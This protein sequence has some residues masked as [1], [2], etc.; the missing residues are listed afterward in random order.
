MN[1]F[2]LV[3]LLFCLIASNNLFS[4]NKDEEDEKTDGTGS[5]VNINRDLVLHYTFDEGTSSTSV[6]TVTDHSSKHVNGVV[7]GTAEFVS[8]TP[9]GNGY[10]L[11]LRKNDYVNIPTYVINDST[12]V[13]VVMWV[14]DFG[15]GSLFRS[16][17]GNNLYT[18]HVS[19]NSSDQLVYLCADDYSSNY[20]YFSTNMAHYQTG[21]WH[22]IAVTASRSN[23]K[24]CLYID[25]VLFDTKSVGQAKCKGETMQ[26]GYNADPMLVDNVRVYARC[27]NANEVKSIYD[28]E[29]KK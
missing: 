21:T 2:F 5:S 17:N 15:Q 24:N 6:Q 20:A 19:I 29:K 1:Q 9:N 10:A 13:S 3:S 12:N 23:K 16:L 22:Q 18:P 11:K 8:D 26:I 4:C 27:L 28:N 25:G 14:K 7:N